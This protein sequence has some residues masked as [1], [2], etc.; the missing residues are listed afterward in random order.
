MIIAQCGCGY[1]TDVFL[2]PGELEGEINEEIVCIIPAE[3]NSCA[4]PVH[5]SDLSWNYTKSPYWRSE[6]DWSNFKT[7]KNVEKPTAAVAAPGKVVVVFPQPKSQQKSRRAV[8][9]QRG[10]EG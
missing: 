10:R 5:D 3:C 7:P 2:E 1:V 4:D 6:E 8:S 9:N